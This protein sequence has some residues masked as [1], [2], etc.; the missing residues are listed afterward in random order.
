MTLDP[1]W[2]SVPEYGRPGCPWGEDTPRIEL[3]SRNAP[4]LCYGCWDSGSPR[5]A[6]PQDSLGDP[7]TPPHSPWQL[8]PL[9][10]SR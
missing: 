10:A 7:R 4:H 2:I 9:G 3:S 5:P 6:E 8:R 1:L